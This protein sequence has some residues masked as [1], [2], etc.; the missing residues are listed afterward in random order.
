MHGP[1]LLTLAGLAASLSTEGDGC[2]TTDLAIPGVTI[3]RG[4]RPTADEPALFDPRLYVV[5]QGRKRM[6]FAGRPQAM[7]PGMFALSSIGVPFVTA[8][9]DA[10]P[11]R[12]YLGV[13]L[14][15]DA[16]EL[17]SLLA[18]IPERRTISAPS[19][20]MGMGDRN[21]LDP[22]ARMLEAAEQP[23]DAMILGPLI[24]RELLYRLLIGEAADTVR[25]L[26]VGSHRI[27]Q[28]RRVATILRTTT[29]PVPRVEAL[30]AEVGMSVTSLHRHFKSVTGYGPID[31]AKHLRLLAARAA[32]SSGGTSIT[33]AAQV[34]G[35]LSASQF[36]REYRK[37]F[38]VQ[39]RHDAR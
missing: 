35:Y 34:A 31:Y 21:L 9:T 15:L 7:T 25:Q 26:V 17:S 3:W 39:P 32:L 36:S 19:I 24:V 27:D 38:N 14:V 22:L 30:A 23:Q 18:E 29:G 2:A 28:V 11:D 33:Q 12:P 8:I 10:S 16:M 1:Q 6:T 13:G 37:K 20:M 5:L 4:D